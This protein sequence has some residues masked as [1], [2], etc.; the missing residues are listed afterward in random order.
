[1]N[2][3]RLLIVSLVVSAAVVAGSASPASADPRMRACGTLKKS[4]RTLR[5]EAGNMTCRRARLML[6]APGT[7]S[8]RVRGYS[9]YSYTA[10]GCEGIVWKDR[11]RDYAQRHEGR[12]PSTAKVI[13]YVVIRGCDS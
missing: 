8:G 7:S 10:A 1:M 6:K 2:A 5:F 4:D 12:L 9:A 13:R 11:D 3:A